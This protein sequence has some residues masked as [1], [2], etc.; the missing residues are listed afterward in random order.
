LEASPILQEIVRKLLIRVTRNS[1]RQQQQQQ[2]Q[3]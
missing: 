1:Q 3:Q 2:Q